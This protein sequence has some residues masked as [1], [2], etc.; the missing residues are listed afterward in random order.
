MDLITVVAVVILLAVYV[1][2]A[3]AL[4][5]VAIKT[6]TPNAWLAWIPIANIYLTTAIAQVPLWNFLVFLAFW[7]VS[8]LGGVIPFLGEGFIPIVGSIATAGLTAWWWW[9]IAEAR[10]KQ[11]WLGLLM[12]VPI[13][14]FVIVGIIAWSD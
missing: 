1:Y 12:L 14:N 3:F 2:F 8:L 13:L 6:K 7:F 4:Q 9:R 10:N 11:G 5:T